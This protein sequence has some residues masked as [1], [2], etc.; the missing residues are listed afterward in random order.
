MT[1]LKMSIGIKPSRAMFRFSTLGGT[2]IDEILTYTE[3][4]KNSKKLFKHVEQDSNKS[5]FRLIGDTCS[6]FVG[7]HDIQYSVDHYDSKSELEISIEIERFISLF[8]TVNSSLKIRDIRR[9]GLVCEYRTPSK[10][11]LPSKELLDK[12]TSFEAVG[13]PA[14]FQLQFE[15]RHPI[16]G[17]TGI[18]DFRTD[19]FWNIIESYYDAEVDE[20]HSTSRHIN[21]MLDVQR[22]YNPLLEDK[23]DNAI[24]S[25]ADKYNKQFGLFLEKAKT[26][27]VVDGR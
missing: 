18:P 17:A 8:S 3:K 2:L 4:S 23:P 27:G 12:F 10:T 14:K 19:D 22:Y 7:T 6:L 1:P 9:I 26:L 5:H 13:Y 25:L 15:H 11:E 24:R 20:A 21:L 16:V